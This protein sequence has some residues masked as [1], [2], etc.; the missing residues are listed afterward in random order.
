MSGWRSVRVRGAGTGAAVAAMLAALLTGCS[1]DTSSP[2]GAADPGEQPTATA[3]ETASEVPVEG[4]YLTLD[5]E[6]RI[7]ASLRF[8]P[9]YTHWDHVV[10]PEADLTID[11]I[12]LVAADNVEVVGRGLV[13]AQ[14]EKVGVTGFSNGWPIDARSAASDRLAWDER[15]PA[16]GGELEAGTGYNLFVHLRLG[17]RGTPASYEAMEIH[18]TVAGEQLVVRDAVRLEIRE[19][20]S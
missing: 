11:R 12:G 5:G 15:R 7:C 1:D 3:T 8:G 9:D 17:R 18:Y 10:T 13:A 19:R 14:P 2:A 6:G 4:G 20:C 16:V